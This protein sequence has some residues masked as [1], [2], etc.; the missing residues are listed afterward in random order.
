MRKQ[1]S[2]IKDVLS[3]VILQ[4]SGEKKRKI[5]RIK[6]AWKDSEHAA[7]VAFKSGR[8]V[9]NIDSSAWMYE[10]NLKKEQIRSGL[11]ER[12]KK[13]DIIINDIILRIGD[14]N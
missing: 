11:N 6:E 5:G 13:D 1:A 10:L 7:P 12:L 14:I 4:M 2:S 3:S 8:L 9:V